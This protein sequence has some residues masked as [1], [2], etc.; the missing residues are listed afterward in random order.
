MSS[1]NHSLQKSWL[2]QQRASYKL[3]FLL[4][5][6]SLLLGVQ[7]IWLQLL[8]LGAVSVLVL[9]AGLIT[10]RFWQSIRSYL[11]LI[12]CIFG[13]SAWLQGWGPASVTGLRMMSLLLLA[14]ALSW[15]T[16]VSELMD[17]VQACLKPLDRLGWVNSANITLTFGLTLRMIPVL[18]SQ[19][20]EIREAQIARGL[21]RHVLICI[22]PMLVRT[23]KRAQEVADAIDV[24]QL[25]R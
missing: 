2:C 6:S 3:L 16:P 8:G 11:W 12:V 20:Q 25:N 14:L 10:K 23:L 5:F 13:Y 9:V 19:W 17:V 18:S 7:V 15:T 22:V 21:D 1:T 24:R 4:V